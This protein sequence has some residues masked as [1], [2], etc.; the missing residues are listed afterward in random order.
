MAEVLSTGARRLPVLA[1][2]ENVLH[3]ERRLWSPGGWQANWHRILTAV[4][5]VA[6]LAGAFFGVNQ[7]AVTAGYDTQGFR[8]GSAILSPAGT[9]AY[10]GAGAIVILH[11]NGATVGASSA[12]IRG[13]HVKGVCSMN[14]DGLS[15]HCLFFQGS[16][17]FTAV[18]QKSEGS[19]LRRYDNGEQVRI[20]LVGGRSAPIPFPVGY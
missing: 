14:D 20:H 17:S 12:V 6:A 9:D 11:Q 8:V 16:K 2:R 19:W 13:Q 1:E 3:D 18:D 7:A 5:V 10:Q 15:A 4:G